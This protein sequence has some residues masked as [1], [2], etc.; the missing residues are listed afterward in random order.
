M[1]LPLQG[2]LPP[3]AAVTGAV[4]EIACDESGFSGTNLL[5]PATPVI[6][7][8]SVDL[9]VDEAVELIA[10]LRSGFRCSPNEFKSGQFLR[11]PKAGEALAWFLTA[12]SGRAHVHL[13]DKEYFLV[14]RVVDLFLAEPSYAAGTRLTQDHR[15]A[16][17][18]LYRARRPAGC[19]WGAF[20]AAFVELVRIKR[21]HRPD[22][23]A[24]ERF[25]QARDALV[26]DGLGAQAEAVLDGLDQTR[27]RAV[28]TRLSDHDRS[29]PPPLEPMLPALAE[30]VL[31]WS[32]GQRQVLV[33][34]DEQSAL[35]A[36]RLSR[37]QQVLA[38][39]AG[40]SP[41]GADKAGV[42][43]AGVS[44]LAGLVMVDSRDDP[45]VQVA[46]LLAGMARRLPGIVD[47]GPLQPFLSPTSLRDPER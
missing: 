45:R 46:D 35:T 19:D 2:G 20:L 23:P 37:L 28:L 43:P 26:R 17:L 31:F 15:P 5:Q 40:S 33:I 25:F 22:L 12:L 11:S 18:A 36:G 42:S 1:R 27:V 4:V 44:P 29:I 8:A 39:S 16:A 14:T 30:T 47:D 13:V 3:A 32:G 21:R 24:L 34:H 6:T 41:V 9:R 38:D 7:H 10:A